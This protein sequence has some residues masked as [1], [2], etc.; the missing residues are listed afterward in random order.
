MLGRQLKYVA[1][2]PPDSLVGVPIAP[3]DAAADRRI[4][5]NERYC[6]ALRLAFGLIAWCSPRAGMHAPCLVR[7]FGRMQLLFSSAL[8]TEQG[9]FRCV[10]LSEAMGQKQHA[11]PQQ[12][13]L[14]NI[15]GR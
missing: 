9:T 4:V 14:L 11:A 13:G 8:L 6:S 12:H 10:A 15:A 1:R 5:R 7:I 3:D 2:T